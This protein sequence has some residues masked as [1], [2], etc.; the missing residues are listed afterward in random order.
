MQQ[1]YGQHFFC[2]MIFYSSSFNTVQ[3]AYNQNHSVEVDVVMRL[4][5]C[6]TNQQDISEGKG[7]LQKESLCHLSEVRGAGIDLGT[8]NSNRINRVLQQPNVCVK[9]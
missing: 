2:E 8:G 4:A 9:S 5:V 3:E 6:A 7:R 1:D